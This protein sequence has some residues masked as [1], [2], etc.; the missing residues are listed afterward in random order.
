MQAMVQSK[1]QQGKSEVQALDSSEMQSILRKAMT[2]RLVEEELLA[3]FSLGK[4]YGTVHTCIGQEMV[5]AVLTQ[6]LIAADTIFS[7][8]RCHGH[9]LGR[10]D[11]IEGL[12]A[13]LMGRQTGVCGGLGGSQHLCRDGFFSNGI[14]G[15]IVPVAA[16][17]ALG[18]KL[19]GNG[20][21]SLVF[22]GDGTLGEGAVYETMNIAAKWELPLLVVIEN[23]Q[24]SQ[25]TAQ[26]ETLA[27]EIDARA[28][29]FGIETARGNTWDWQKLHE[30]S[31]DL[32]HQIRRDSKPRV[33][34]I[35]TYRLKAHSK[36]DDTRPRELVQPY[37]L[38]DP[39]N[40]FLKTTDPAD[41]AWVDA[42]QAR[43]KAAVV[44]A[45]G[46][47]PARMPTRDD[48]L[49]GKPEWISA[50]P[51]PKTRIVT[52]LN[53]CL[54]EHMKASPETIMIGEDILSPYGGAFKVTKGLSDDFPGRVRN[55]PI[56]EAAIVGIGTG[57]GLLEFRPLVEIMFGD[58]IGLGFDQLL[59]HAAKFNQMYNN[60]VTTNVIVRTPMGGGRG[61]G[62]T[63]S[64]TLD[65]HFFGIPGLRVVALSSLLEPKGVYDPLLTGNHGPSLVIE[66]KLLYGTFPLWAVPDGFQL[67]HSTVTFPDA[68]LRP[69]S[70]RCD[71]T[72][73]GYGGTSDLLVQA[74]E[75]LFEDYDVVAQVL[76]V[77]QIY[78]FDITQIEEVLRRAPRL[79]VVEEGQ[80]YSG[81]GAEVIAQ[82]TERGNPDGLAVAR[83]YPPAYCIPSSGPLEKTVLPCVDQIVARSLE[84]TRK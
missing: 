64:Q 37:E 50:S 7:N 16:G 35:D 5:G 67:L 65:K 82:I 4:L 9:Y 66:N 11:D 54:R 45:E 42:I 71:V 81:F 36:G 57:L 83:L 69:D 74:A 23:N 47:D 51:L 58:F 77:T 52:L 44:T 48:T 10:T 46:D 12:I 32:I 2:A 8:H 59:N 68:W 30:I 39:L 55:T 73:L 14:Q 62:P 34:H 53:D 78:P 21:V 1:E 72:L 43:V 19:K 20:A 33:L 6:H 24:Y 31:K 75:R 63:H 61:Y 29:A 25:S 13:E 56:S 41:R 84:L 22:I 3:L 38:R 27:G 79:L 80:G 17:L 26:H 49:A 15:G 76:V 18:H 60:Q 70:N 40:L 28:H